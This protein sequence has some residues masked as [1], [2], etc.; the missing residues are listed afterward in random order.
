MTM[1]K[2][3]M[4]AIYKSLLTLVGFLIIISISIGILYIFYDKVIEPDSDIEVFGN[5]SINFI[6]GKSFEIDNNKTIKFSITNSSS[7]VEYYSISFKQIRG[8]GYY[9]LI[10]QDKVVTEGNIETIDEITTE[11]ISIDGKETK[12]YVLELV[13]KSD[14]ALKGMLNIRTQNNKVVTFADKI[15]ENS[16]YSEDSLTNIGEEIATENE[17]LIKSSDDLGVSYYFRGKIDN[18]YVSFGDMLWRIVRINGDGTVRI[19]L[20]GVT[21][22]LASYYTKENKN[23]TYDESSMN[24]YLE[25]WLN[26]NLSDEINYIANTKYCSD[27]GYDEANVFYSYTRIYT[28]KISTLNCLGTKINNNIGLLTA[29]E[30]ILAG[31]ITGN[32]NLNYYLYNSEIKESWYTMTGAL[33]TNDSISMFMVDVNGRIVTNIEGN[34]YRNVRPVINLLKNIEIDGIGTK[35]DPYVIK[36]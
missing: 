28:N 3:K 35:E 4:R 33:G 15:L 25:N 1:V 16:R 22:V 12:I 13:N 10:Y 21:D 30:V 32:D 31:A 24:K 9:K 34:L 27:I 19:V 5:L 23:F 29:D 14:I 17:G 36:E 8:S 18:N 7:E 20:D 6:D 11:N 2:L 26:D